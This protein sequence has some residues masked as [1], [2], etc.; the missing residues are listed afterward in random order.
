MSTNTKLAELFEDI[1]AVLELLGENPF[2]VAAHAKVARVLRDLAFDIASVA[3]DE[4]R[5]TAIDGI[6]KGTAEKIREFISKGRIA[7]HDE[8][9]KKVPHGLLD[10]LNI[11]GLGPKTVKLM[12]EQGGVTDMASLKKKLDTGELEQLPRLGAKT[13]KNI[14]DAMEFTAKA[15]ERTCIGDALPVAERIIEHLASLKLVTHIEY[16]GSLRRGMETI[17]DI[18]ILASTKNPAAL[19]KAFAELPG[20]VKVLAS[21]ETKSSIR[22]AEGI[23]VDLRII[24][25]ACFGAALMYFTGSKEH[26]IALR[27]RAIKMGFRLNE[28]GLFADDGES[29]KP[30][31]ERGVAPIAAQTEASVYKK[32]DLPFIPP[33]LRE[34][35]GEFDAKLPSLIEI[36]DIKA[37]LHAHTIASDGRMTIEQLVGEAKKR[38]FHTIAVTDHSKSSAQA[39]GLSAERLLEH[40]KA[41]RSA[42]KKLKDITILAGSEVD[43]LANG[44]LDYEDELLAKLDIVI[45]SPHASLR[46]EADVATARILKAIAHPLVHII[47]H[48]TGRLIGQ[49]PGLPIDLPQIIASAKEHDTALEIN[50]HSLRLDLRDTHVRAA[51]EAGV[52]I[53]INTDA[54]SDEDFDQLRYGILTG[55]RGWLT[56]ASC[57]NT[58]PAPKLHKW[59]K[60]KRKNSN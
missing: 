5:L 42:Q 34:N 29:K 1:A 8:L 36:T 52:R 38:G 6:G 53:A 25:D 10:V 26:N 24:D 15:S 49:R 19:A 46:Q 14:K 43:I 11:P 18:D 4:K 13:L 39:N 12:W 48:P 2:R 32:L 40:I 33:E 50:S 47:G 59:L 7:E 22:L 31:Q 51:V 55:R 54:H 58:W 17:G 56:P 45:A 44:S 37:E 23:Q 30:P 41:I 60:S 9:M 3:G 35:R 16:A 28:Y 21:G 20:V 27:E 57:I